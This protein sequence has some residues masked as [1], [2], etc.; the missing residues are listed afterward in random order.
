METLHRK[1]ASKDYSVKEKSTTNETKEIFQQPTDKC[2]HQVKEEKIIKQSN[3]SNN[4]SEIQD[5][6]LNITTIQKIGKEAIY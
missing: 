5:Q 6:S 2:V 1:Q 3:T 4:E